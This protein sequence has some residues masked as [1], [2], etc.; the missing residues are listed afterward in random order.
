MPGRSSVPT[1]LSSPC[2][3]QMATSC[4]VPLEGHCHCPIPGGWHGAGQPPVLHHLSTA[5]HPP[6]G[7]G[8][9][10]GKHRQNLS[11]PSN[12]PPLLLQE[13]PGPKGTSVTRPRRAA[14]TCPQGGGSGPMD[15]E[16]LR[17]HM[18]TAGLP[19]EPAAHHFQ[20]TA[21]TLALS[22]DRFLP[23]GRQV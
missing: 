19:A 17:P 2:D 14:A 8:N 4:F 5:S 12:S 10:L 3:V 21:G 11:L 20:T 22:T 18:P 9:K 7:G 15:R 1:D 6:P 13:Y 16:A 23:H